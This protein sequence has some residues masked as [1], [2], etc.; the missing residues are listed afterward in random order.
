MTVAA[1]EVAEEAWVEEEFE[2]VVVC[3]TPIL[4]PAATIIP[5]IA[6]RVR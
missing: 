6:K 4:K 5:M 3:A 2:S 1:G